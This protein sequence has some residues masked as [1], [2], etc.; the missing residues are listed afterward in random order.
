MKTKFGFDGLT[1]SGFD[2]LTTGAF[3]ELR[4]DGRIKRKIEKTKIIGEF[5]EWE[6]VSTKKKYD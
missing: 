4:V 2:G 1:A 6:N 5:M 3:G